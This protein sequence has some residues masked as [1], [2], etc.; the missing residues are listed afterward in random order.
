MFISL[1]LNS[2][3]D[4]ISSLHTEFSEMNNCDVSESKVSPILMT[5][6][7]YGLSALALTQ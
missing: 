5:K 4:E 3:L 1:S 7:I 2:E 6:A